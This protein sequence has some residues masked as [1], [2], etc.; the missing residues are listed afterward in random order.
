MWILNPTNRINL[1]VLLHLEPW[2]GWTTGRPEV[3]NV[4]PLEA[5]GDGNV[6]DAASEDLA[7][8]SRGSRS[9]ATNKRRQLLG[10]GVQVILDDLEGRRGSWRRTTG[11]PEVVVAFISKSTASHQAPLMQSTHTARQ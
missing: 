9:P 5:D 10:V 2:A 8:C 11:L 1:C 4:F 7:H 3:A 6:A